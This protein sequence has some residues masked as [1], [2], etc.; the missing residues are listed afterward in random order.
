MRNVFALSKIL[1][2]QGMNVLK[3]ENG[4]KA[5]E[6]IA[7]NPDISLVLMDIMMPEMDGLEAIRRIRTMENFKELPVLTLTAKAMKEDR[8]KKYRRGR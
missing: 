5:L 4:L 8:K 2:E 3:A 6:A 7:N 1:K